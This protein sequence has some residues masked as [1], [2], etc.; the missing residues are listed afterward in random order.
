MI[1]F[2]ISGCK[3][4]GEKF[5]AKVDDEGI[6]EEEFEMDFKVYKNIHE[7]QR[8]SD[9][10]SQI[11][12]DGR[13]LGEKLK[14]DIVNKL[15]MERI[16]AKET[17]KMGISLSQEE[18]D[19]KVEE[20]IALAGGQDQYDEFLETSDI[21]DEYYK[22]SLRKE[23]LTNK[24]KTELL[25]GIT[26]EEEDAKNYF[27]S[28]KEDLVVIK[29]S[30]ILVKTEEEGEEVL[31]RLERGEDFAELAK[32]ISID[33]R[34]ALKGGDLGY[35]SRGTMI[36]DFEQVAFNLEVGEVSE[37]TKTE[38][39][40]H[41]IYLEDRKDTFETLRDNIYEL[42]KEYKYLEEMQTLRQ[43]SNVKIFLDLKE[44]K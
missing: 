43:N 20:F 16:I 4:N 7:R 12:E 39:G 10:L 44:E 21:T 24:H 40:Y 34:S 25:K 14:E 8:G 15:I 35:L 2:L 31:K 28:N 32:E 6:T 30:L 33:K 29:P 9:A 11:V 36:A 23:L 27:E 42:L 41:I 5:I 3:S 1:V 13:T 37:L 19:E 38:V 17:E 22:E 18:L 26:I